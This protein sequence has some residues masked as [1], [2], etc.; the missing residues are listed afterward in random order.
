METIAKQTDDFGKILEKDL[1]RIIALYEDP[2]T[3]ANIAKTPE[4]DKLERSI[5]ARLGIRV[6]VITTG[7]LCAVLP[8]YTNKNTIFIDKF[9]RGKFTIKEQERYLEDFK[10]KRGYVDDKK[11]RVGGIFSEYRVPLYMNFA[12]L[13]KFT[14]LS[15]EEL[16]AVLLHELGHAYYACSF[17]DRLESGGQVM[18][19]VGRVMNGNEP[20]KREMIFREIE[21]INPKITEE[22]VEQILNEDSTVMGV[23]LFKAILDGIHSQ[24][25]NGKYDETSFEQLADNFSSRFGYGRQLISGLEKLTPSYSVEKNKVRGNIMSVLGLMNVA[26]MA[27]SGAAMLF[28]VSTLG[29]G[30]VVMGP[31]LIA[32]S[33]FILFVEGDGARDYTYDELK[34]RYSRIRNEVIVMLKDKS[35]S[36]EETKELLERMK[37]MDD[38]IDKTYLDNNLVRKLSNFIF[39]S[40]RIA[41]KEIAE[42][43]LVE[44]LAHNR[45]YA[46]SAQFAVNR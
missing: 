2:D 44:A 7:A 31:Y 36:K 43:Q 25:P 8:F 3:P 1:S 41:A 19:E 33:S 21:K 28:S 4:V 9:W 37:Y 34:I 38:I 11:A 30:A 42:Q 29:M 10:T 18:L 22:E 35:L 16:A 6:R 20:R 24:S 5:Y 39:S 14:E 46:T 23:K 45:L 32:V 26:G 17:A 15:K 12:V 27:L 40:N 13:S